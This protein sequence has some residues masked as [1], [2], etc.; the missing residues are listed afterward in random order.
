MEILEIVDSCTG[1]FLVKRNKRNILTPAVSALLL[2]GA[3][4]LAGAGYYSNNSTRDELVIEAFQQAE[5]ARTESVIE[6]YGWFSGEV[7]KREERIAVLDEIAGR[8]NLSQYDLEHTDTAEQ[9]VSTLHQ[10]DERMEVQVQII[11]IDDDDTERQQYMLMTVKLYDGVDAALEYRELTEAIMAD[12]GI[13]ASASMGLKGTYE[14]N[15]TLAQRGEIADQLVEVLAADI[16]T[17]YRSE[18]LFTI[19][20]YSRYLKEYK[21]GSYDDINVNI[22]MSYSETENVTYLHVST[23][24]IREDY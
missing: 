6:A 15:M 3:V 11:T 16:I 23:P 9:V 22:A 12:Y 4:V 1:G 20:A 5:C 13:S 21:G 19:Y 14:G 17:E 8:L 2:W 24:V 18:E 7:L 10:Q